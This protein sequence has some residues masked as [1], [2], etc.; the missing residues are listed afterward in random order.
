MSLTFKS[1]DF[2]ELYTRVVLLFDCICFDAVHICSPVFMQQCVHV[3]VLRVLPAS[4]LLLHP[5]VYLS[6]C[7]TD[8]CF[9]HCAMLSSFRPYAVVLYVLAELLL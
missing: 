9:P 5:S 1:P 6:L 8:C 7:M 4:Y 3:C 2:G